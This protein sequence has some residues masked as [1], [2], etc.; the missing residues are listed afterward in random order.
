MNLTKGKLS[1]R[2]LVFIVLGVA[3]LKVVDLAVGS[4]LTPN[5]SV[6]EQTTRSLLLK[7]YAPNTSIK[8][9]PGETYLPGTN[10]LEQKD[11]LL[12]TDS[13]GFI[14]GPSDSSKQQDKVST[15]FFGGSTTECIFVEEDMRFPYR[16]GELLNV[17]TLNGGVSGNHTMHSLLQTIGKAIPYNPKYIVFLQGANDAGMLAK[18]RSYWVAPTNRSIIQDSKKA[19]EDFSRYAI[20]RK[21]KDA[22][23]PNLWL[24]FGYYFQ[25]MVTSLIVDEWKDYRDVDYNYA[26]LEKTVDSEFTAAMRSIVHLSRDWGI[27]PILMTQFSRIKLDDSETRG[28]YEKYPQA[29]SYSEYVKLYNMA[30]DIIRQVAREEKV[31]LI[32]L[33]KLVP[34]S[35]KFMY[36]SL[37]LNT[38]GSK[39]VSQIISQKM[40]SAFPSDF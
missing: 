14:I 21:I 15:I 7:E 24:R 39:L 6:A 28:E 36:D 20:A 29:L 17:R 23:I 27:E 13:D 34:S 5:N 31:V 38:E 32:D 3:A 19:S 37:H 9:R 30:N 1:L 22:L 12:R 4:L 40:R 18:T 2:L 16:V 26:E 33:D 35:S 25:G 8:I 10:A 11:F